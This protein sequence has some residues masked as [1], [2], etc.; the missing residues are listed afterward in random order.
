[1]PR[2]IKEFHS[3]GQLHRLAVIDGRQVISIRVFDPD[4]N[5]YKWV[6]PRPWRVD[7]KGNLVAPKQ[8]VKDDYEAENPIPEQVESRRSLGENVV[9]IDPQLVAFEYERSRLQEM[10]S[11][12][13]EKIERIQDMAETAIQNSE[14]IRE[15]LRALEEI[16]RIAR[17]STR[18]VFDEDR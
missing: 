9:R 18:R 11:T 1:M 12:L 4:G 10:V 5:E 13:L 6:N 8:A 15:T 2:S 3:N 17:D 14:H 16:E 7:A